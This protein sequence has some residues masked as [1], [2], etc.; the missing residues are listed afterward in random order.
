MTVDDLDVSA[1]L[2]YA[3]AYL[4]LKACG[5]AE[6]DHHDENTY[7]DSCCGYVGG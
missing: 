3:L 5:D 7:G 6:T 1:S 2:G 4:F